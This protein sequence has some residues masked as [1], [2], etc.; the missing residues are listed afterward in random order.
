MNKI[1]KRII[2]GVA[3]FGAAVVIL[4]AI[5]VGVFRLM[6]PRLPE[7]QEDIKAWASDAIGVRVEFSGMNARWRLS[8]PEVSFFDAELV[9]PGTESNILSAEEVSIGVGLLRL[10]KDRELVVDRVVV[11]DTS[12][13]LRKNESGDWTF[14][15]QSVEG[16]SGPGESAAADNGFLEIIGENIVVNYEHPATGQLVQFDIRTASVSREGVETSI[17]AVIDLPTEFGNRIEFSAS[18]VGGDAASG[19]WRYYVEGDSLFLPGWSRFRPPELPQLHSGTVDMSLWL[20]VVNGE[21][22]S[23]TSNMTITDLIAGGQGELPPLDMQGRFDFSIETGGWLLAAEQF[24]LTTVDGGWPDTSLQVRVNLN[25]EGSVETIRSSATYLNFDDLAYAVPWLTEEQRARLDRIAPSGEIRELRAEVSELQSDKP[26]FDVTAELQRI[27]FA[28]EDDWPGLHGFSGRLRAD[29]NG[30]R[31]EIESTDLTVDLGGHLAEPIT[32][33]DAFGTVIWR[34]SIDG[35]VVLSDSI[36]IRNADL[37]SES[38][39]QVSMPADGSAPVVDFES[40]WSIYNVGSMSRYLPLRLISPALHT[41]LSNALVSGRASRGTTVFNGAV[42][43]FPFENGEGIFRIDA[44]LE[45]ATLKYANTWP[46]AE[47]RHLNLIVENTRLYSHENSATNLGNDVEDADI[48]IADLRDPV[49]QIE[50][51]A[52]GSLETIRQYAIQSPIHDVLGGQLDRVQVDGDA[53]FD[54]SLTVPIRDRLNFDFATRIRSNN[55]TVAVTG[56]SAPITE[57]NGIVTV[58]RNEVSSEALFG[59][60]LDEHVDIV[61]SRTDSASDAHSVI[62]EAAGNFT[63]EGLKT[64]L[65]VPTD[66]IGQGQS[67]YLATVRFPNGQAETPGSLQIQ[68]ESDLQG[69]ELTL[70]SPLTKAAAEPVPLSATIEFP[71]AQSVTSTGSLNGDYAW[72]FEFL[73]ESDAWTFDRGV[74][75]IGGD[76]PNDPEIRGLRIEGQTSEI[77]LQDWLDLA[78]REDGGAGV[79]SLI[80]AIDLRVDDLYVIGQHYQDHRVEVN[81]SGLDW[82][83]QITGNQA[84]GNITVP[85]DFQ[86]GRVMTLDMNRLVLPGEES[87]GDK[88]T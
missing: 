83:V 58:T 45:N 3:Y 30:G 80:R 27:G 6:L 21:L 50:A 17:D 39:L 76:Y 82:V 20:N 66:A 54:L 33:D 13:D 71:S 26:Q 84:D 61:L 48:E 78:R 34:R 14:Q 42:D 59:K 88:N 41:W 37:E 49:L 62:L 10:I 16:I 8:G 70:P 63:A 55:G 81:R 31:V 74:L 53:S 67:A 77:K 23:A 85:Y 2:K 11:R 73:K 5:A 28:A 87:S 46:A 24:R 56:L 86:S 1:F 35:F 40:D 9:Q 64:G 36:R 52:T 47:F 22:Q 19:L 65:G 72:K 57:L 32:F 38:S 68:I 69:F 51:F 7:Y 44:N 79:G 12:I 25:D 60:F 18:Q 75:S 29:R 4:L 43:E 15:G